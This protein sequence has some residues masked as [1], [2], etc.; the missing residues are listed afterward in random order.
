MLRKRFLALLLFQA[1]SFHRYQQ[2]LQGSYATH[3]R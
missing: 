3:C 2:V 1:H